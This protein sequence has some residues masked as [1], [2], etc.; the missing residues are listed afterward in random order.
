MLIE[1]AAGL[2]PAGI[3]KARTTS[4]LDIELFYAAQTMMMI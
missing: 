2:Q 4:E 1:R 3:S